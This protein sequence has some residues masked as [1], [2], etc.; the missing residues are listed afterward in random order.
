MRA[1]AFPLTLI[2]AAIALLVV[3]SAT[4]VVTER[5]QAIQLRFGEIQRV[6]TDPGIYFKVPTNMVDTVQI[7]DKR[8]QTLELE[9]NVVQVNDGSP[10]LVDAFATY[11]IVDARS[12]R[13]SVSGNKVFAEDRLRTRLNSALRRV[14]GSR[15]FDAA[16]S[17]ARAEM[18]REVSDL[19]R[20][21]AA[22]LGIAIVELR[23]RRTELLEDVLERTFDRM[24]SERLAEAAELRAEGTQEAQRIRAEADRAATVLV[25][26]A[27]RDADFLRGE[28]DAEKNRIFAEAYSLDPSFFEFY[29]SM[30]AYGEALGAGSGTTMVL[31][32][33]SEFF[34]FFNSSDAPGAAPPAA[35]AP[36]PAAP[37]APAPQATAPAPAPTTP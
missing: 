3:Y 12:F 15:S 20:P 7:I 29:R 11:R 32:P 16:L 10:Y 18:M 6:I 17:T 13:E 35:T 36:A 19:V 8:L 31:S 22:S 28:G 21:E 33:T 23:I 34:R 9:N 5:D 27:Q 25:A 37:A 24:R 14:Y 2:V 1:I 26:E 4:F 30:Q